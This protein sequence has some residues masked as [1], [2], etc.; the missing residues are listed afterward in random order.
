MS[1]KTAPKSILKKPAVAGPSKLTGSKGK[2]KATVAVKTAKVKAPSPEPESSDDNDFPDDDEYELD[3]EDEIELAQAGSE[4]KQPSKSSSQ[5]RRR[6]I[7]QL[8][9]ERKR[10]TTASEFGSTLTSLLAEPTSKKAKKVKKEDDK[11]PKSQPI[12]ALSAK[13]LP[14]SQ[15]AER[16]ERRAARVLKAERM[17]RLDRAR[18]RD[19]VEGWVPAPGAEMGSQEFERALRKTAQRGGEYKRT[20]LGASSGANEQ[21]SNCSM[22]FL[23]RARTPRRPPRRCPTRLDL[24]PRRPR[25]GR[26]RTT[27]SAVVARTTC[28]P[29]SRSSTLSVAAAPSNFA[30][31]SLYHS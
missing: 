20:E 12:L 4:K 24:S 7:F 17:E 22:L 14:P 26:R 13:P 23:S 10:P 29:R 6:R 30:P 11:K 21:S 1:S 8:T 31:F 19:V 15:A 18:V 28:S 16:L 5:L 27:S 25:A 3:T 9:S 2:A